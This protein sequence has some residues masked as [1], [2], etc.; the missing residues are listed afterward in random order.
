M[1]SFECR[2]T[3]GEVFY[4]HARCPGSIPA[5][6]SARRPSRGAAGS[7]GVRATPVPRREACRRIEAGAR[8][9]RAGRERD[10][11]VTT[12]ERNLGRDP[13]RRF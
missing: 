13:C 6:A 9:G 8:S 5:G 11:T 3:N 12:Y 4:R 1:Q 10:E 7:V 2:A